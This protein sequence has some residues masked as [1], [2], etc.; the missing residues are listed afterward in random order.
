MIFIWLK[1]EIVMY[2]VS[3]LIKTTCIVFHS[4]SKLLSIDF[5]KSQLPVVSRCPLGIYKV[6]KVRGEH[7]ELVIS[8]LKCG[9]KKV[10]LF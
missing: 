6:C 9:Y 7:I 3:F 1:I 8:V 10:R 5:L 2:I 4:A